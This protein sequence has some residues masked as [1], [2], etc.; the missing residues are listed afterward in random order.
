M[1]RHEQMQDPFGPATVEE[2]PVAGLAG[3]RLDARCRLRSDP[4]EDGVVDAARGEQTPVRFASV[5][6]S[7]RSP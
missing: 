6:D 2:Q 1:M 7:G 4:G 5:A 3:R